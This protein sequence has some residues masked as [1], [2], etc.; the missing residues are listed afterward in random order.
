MIET[1]VAIQLVDK[2]D[3]HPKGVLEDVLV[4][5]NELVFPIDFYIL[6]MEDGASSIQ[7]PL[8]LSKLFMKIS[9]TKMCMMGF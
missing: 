6:D 9:R 1:S 3:A 7:T 5:V 8:L 4:Q 2:S